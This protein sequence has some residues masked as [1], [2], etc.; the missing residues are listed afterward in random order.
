MGGIA[1]RT[2]C[3]NSSASRSIDAQSGQDRF[4]IGGADANVLLHQT[5]MRA[6]VE[7]LEERDFG[8]GVTLGGGQFA[9]MLLLPCPHRLVQHKNGYGRGGLAIGRD[10]ED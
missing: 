9:A 2:I 7:S 8:G 5:R 10:V 1:M 6:L 3:S 4:D